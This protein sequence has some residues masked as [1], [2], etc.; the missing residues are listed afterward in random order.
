MKE[1]LKR[2]L[3]WYPTSKKEMDRET[4]EFKLSAHIGRRVQ[5]R[6]SRGCVSGYLRKTDLEGHVQVQGTCADF[7]FTYSEVHGEYYGGLNPIIYLT[8]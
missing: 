8:I 3:G 1:R 5:V 7:H 4:A 6:H 2:L